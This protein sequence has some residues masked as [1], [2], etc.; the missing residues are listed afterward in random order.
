[1]KDYI[2]SPFYSI[3]DNKL[4]Y[5]KE[6]EICK[7]P[8]EDEIRKKIL[9][10]EGVLL[11]KAKIL[12]QDKIALVLEPHPD[13]FVLSALGYTLNRYNVIVG[14][15]FSKTNINSF[16]WIN[17]ILINEYEYEK[18]RIEESK[19]SIQMLLHQE[20][21]S[22][23]EESLRISKKSYSEIEERIWKFVKQILQENNIDIIMIPMGIGNHPDHLIVYDTIMNNNEIV[24]NIKIIL[25]PEYP[26]ARSKKSY[27]ERLKEI[28]NKYSLNKVIININEEE[29]NVFSNAISAYRSQFDDINKNQML[30]IIREDY[31]ALAQENNQNNEIVVYYEVK[32]DKVGKELN[33][34]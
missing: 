1:M 20:F 11:E 32:G 28:E 10:D 22:L 21:T 34:D 9:I 27:I 18:L 14:N 16:T 13:D 12:P 6:Y 7:L 25:Y 17:S 4:F 3:K 30:A 24:K 31:R 5:L 2:M 26:Y 8:V 15:I 19:L 33:F 29:I 23:F